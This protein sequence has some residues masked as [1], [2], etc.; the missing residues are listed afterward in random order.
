MCLGPC[1]L[2][3]HPKC[4]P[5]AV[6]PQRALKGH[7]ANFPS[8]AGI[9]CKKP[10]GQ[11]LCPFQ[12]LPKAPTLQSYLRSRG[13]PLYPWNPI[14]TSFCA[15][16][17]ILDFNVQEMHMKKNKSLKS[18]SCFF[19]SH[20][21]FFPQDTC[22]LVIFLLLLASFQFYILL[23]FFIFLW[24]CLPSSIFQRKV[25]HIFKQER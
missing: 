5:L 10:S 4:A 21:L 3:A 9:K 8:L 11:N 24:P 13:F 15:E 16:K 20:L 25:H 14:T 1:C 12:M 17:P 7:V 19:Q 18:F 2:F 6:P 22:I 23:S